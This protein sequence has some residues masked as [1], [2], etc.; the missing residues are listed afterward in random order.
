MEW[1][2]PY[3]DDGL[4]GVKGELVRL[5]KGASM[6]PPPPAPAVPK[7]SDALEGALQLQEDIRRKRRSLAG[8]FLGG[9]G[10][11]EGAG[12]SQLGE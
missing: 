2:G 12:K 3:W 9:V 11:G 1:F 6:P 10:G 7:E 4:I 5:C 8:S